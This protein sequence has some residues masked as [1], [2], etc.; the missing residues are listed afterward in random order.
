[1]P[2]P[3]QSPP[4][5][6]ARPPDKI[7]PLSNIAPS[8][9]VPLRED[10]LNTDLPRD[11]VERLKRILS[12]IDYQ[13]EGV[14]ENLLYMFEREKRRIMQEAAEMEQAQGPPLIRP[15]LHPSEVDTI[16]ANMEAPAAPGMDYNIRNMPPVEV[17]ERL[18]PNLSIRDKAVMDLLT[19]VE[20]AVLDLQSF[21]NYMAGIKEY[22]LGCLERELARIEDV[23][24]RPEERSAGREG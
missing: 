14:K 4:G 6:E 13:R 21:G 16:I 17:G 7:P 2:P 5:K 19:V 1:M 9:F 24:K 20:R 3:N 11:R 18:S 10:I 12:T 22:Y 8:V 23:G 15:A